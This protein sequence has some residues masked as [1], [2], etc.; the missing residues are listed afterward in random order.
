MTEQ[1]RHKHRKHADKFNKV[2]V[3]S[4]EGYSNATAKRVVTEQEQLSDAQKEADNLLQSLQKHQLKVEELDR[5]EDLRQLMADKPEPKD[6]SHG[7]EM[8]ESAE[9]VRLESTEVQ[10]AEESA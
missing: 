4:G 2:D 9:D 7:V 8:V 3:N 6:K 5:K 1:K 10:S